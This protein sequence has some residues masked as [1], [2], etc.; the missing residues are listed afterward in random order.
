M[1][2]PYATADVQEVFRFIVSFKDTH[3]EIH[4][5][6]TNAHSVDK[7]RS[8]IIWRIGKTITTNNSR[9]VAEGRKYVTSLTGQSE[10]TKDLLEVKL[11]S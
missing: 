4:A 3:G 8:N 10:Y 7:A 11:A 1:I 6:T 2:T 9:I 5:Y